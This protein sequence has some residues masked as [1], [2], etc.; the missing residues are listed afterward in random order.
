MAA[1]FGVTSM[2]HY[3]VVKDY[4]IR[5]RYKFLQDLIWL[6]CAAAGAYVASWVGAHLNPWM[7]GGAFVAVLVGVLWVNAW[8]RRQRG[9][10][11]QIAMTLLS[12]AGV[13]IGFMLRLQ[14]AH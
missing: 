5:R 12:V 7:T 6:P 14:G 13:V 8:E 3:F 10:P 4:R 2:S 9:I 1:T 11:H